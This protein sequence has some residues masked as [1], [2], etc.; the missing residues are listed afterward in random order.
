MSL[1]SYDPNRTG[2]EVSFDGKNWT[3]VADD[4]SLTWSLKSGWNTLRL[5]TAARRGIKGPE[6]AVV[7]LLDESD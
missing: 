7:M 2:Y 6:T 3:G 5:R 4:T 1:D